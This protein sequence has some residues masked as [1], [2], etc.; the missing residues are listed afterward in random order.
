MKANESYLIC[1][2]PEKSAFWEEF[3][4]I[5]LKKDAKITTK[6]ARLAFIHREDM[7]DAW[8]NISRLYQVVTDESYEPCS[9]IKV[10]LEEKQVVDIESSET[11][12]IIKTP[13][14]RDKKHF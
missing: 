7:P 1:A 4:L 10:P 2:R 11:D 6:A 9:I 5:L 8:A 14:T 13:P 12:P 3:I